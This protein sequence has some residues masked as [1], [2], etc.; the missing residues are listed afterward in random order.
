MQDA[1]NELL[2]S[3]INK[4][5]KEKNIEIEAR[6][7]KITH[8][9]TETRATLPSAHPIVFNRLPIEFYFESSVSVGDFKYFIEKIYQ[10][11]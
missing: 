10:N 6:I 3:F 2:K 1:I 5:R 7:G 4:Y 9:I 8:K 11:H